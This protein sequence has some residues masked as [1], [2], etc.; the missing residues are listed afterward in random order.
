M[1]VRLTLMI[2]LTLIGMISV[3]K[4]LIQHYNLFTAKDIPVIS[5][6][7]QEKT[8]ERE[9]IL[10]SGQADNQ[11]P[12]KQLSTPQVKSGQSKTIKPTSARRKDKI[13]KAEANSKIVDFTQPAVDYIK[14][15]EEFRLA[16]ETA[17]VAVKD[18][19]KINY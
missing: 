12:S 1:K 15:I 11:Y 5:D 17:E 9:T 4:L 8:T 18:L 3:A 13:V 16:V 14:S 7:K 19:E 2:I 6:S 10:N